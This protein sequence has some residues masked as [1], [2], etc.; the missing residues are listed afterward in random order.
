VSSSWKELLPL[1]SSFYPPELGKLT[2]P[3]RKGYALGR[4]PFHKSKSGKSFAVNL[5][6][7]GFYCFGC[8]VH[9]DM[10]S[11]V[12]QR[13]K[14]S[15]NDARKVLGAGEDAGKVIKPRPGPRVRYLAMDFSIDGTTYRAEVKDEPVTELQQLRRIHADAHDRLIEIRDGAAEK[16]DAEEEA[17]WGILAA[18]WELIQMEVTDAG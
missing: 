12:R 18:T 3:N 9:G 5:E 13:Y 10:V 1:P 17:Q 6:H 14:L 16:F 8:G 7:G 4:C 15:F 11:F 2:R